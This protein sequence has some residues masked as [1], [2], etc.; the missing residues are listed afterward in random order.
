MIL[1]KYNN[2]RIIVYQ[3]TWMYRDTVVGK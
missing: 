2:D 1:T 3:E